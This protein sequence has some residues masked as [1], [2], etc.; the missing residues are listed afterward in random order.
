MSGFSGSATSKKKLLKKTL[1][2]SN[3][4]VVKETPDQVKG[5]TIATGK[6]LGESCLGN[7]REVTLEG[8]EKNVTKL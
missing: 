2:A 5:V 3:W 7:S 8:G 1:D 4:A 6:L